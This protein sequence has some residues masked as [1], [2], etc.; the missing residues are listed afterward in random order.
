VNQPASNADSRYTHQ[1]IQLPR[2]QH[3]IHVPE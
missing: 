3:E 1:A 2:V